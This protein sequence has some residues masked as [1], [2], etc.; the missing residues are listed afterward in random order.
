MPTFQTSGLFE[1]HDYY[2]LRGAKI[3]QQ[4]L[5]DIFI[6][7]NNAIL[8]SDV[9]KLPAPVLFMQLALAPIIGCS[10]IQEDMERVT[11]IGKAEVLRI[12]KNR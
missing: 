7:D 8:T 11:N 1:Q 3:I 9:S 2:Y 4:R 12:L 10:L 5:M 6:R